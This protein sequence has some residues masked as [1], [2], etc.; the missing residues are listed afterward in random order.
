[1]LSWDF[2][3]ANYGTQLITAE[4]WHV[5]QVLTMFS[6]MFYDATVSLCRVYY[7]TSSLMVHNILEILTH[8]KAYKNDKI[9]LEV[10]AHMKVNYWK[11][12]PTLYAF[13]YILGPR[14]KLDG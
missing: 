11:E 8:M 4:N 3:N 10:I 2:V 14:T 12:T 6:E 13:V 5:A 1:M 7:P 9:L